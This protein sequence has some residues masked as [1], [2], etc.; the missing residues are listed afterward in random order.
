MRA[1]SKICRIGAHLSPIKLRLLS[2][3]PEGGS[4]VEWDNAKVCFI[5]AQYLR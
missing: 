4:G 3:K 2:V 5:K 1:S